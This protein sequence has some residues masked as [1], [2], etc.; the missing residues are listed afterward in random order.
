MGTQLLDTQLVKST[1][2]LLDMLHGL[3]PEL[4]KSRGVKSQRTLF[5]IILSFIKVDA[6]LYS[7]LK[8]AILNSNLG[9]PDCNNELPVCVLTNKIRF[10]NTK[11]FCNTMLCAH[12]GYELKLLIAL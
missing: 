1:S 11:I 8:M 5:N 9:N 3:K 7:I 12:L 6:K 10:S 2:A 4:H